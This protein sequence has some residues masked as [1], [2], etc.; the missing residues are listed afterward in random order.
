MSPNNRVSSRDAAGVVPWPGVEACQ[1]NPPVCVKSTPFLSDLPC[2][3]LSVTET[4]ASTG[5][6]R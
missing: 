4:K 1:G 6:Q 5:A 3:T 2:V